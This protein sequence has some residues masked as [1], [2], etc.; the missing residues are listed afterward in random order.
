MFLVF[1]ILSLTS[2][3]E[4][5]ETVTKQGFAT[6][7]VL[8]TA[9]TTDIKDTTNAID[10]TDTTNIDSTNI[11][12]SDTVPSSDLNDTDTLSDLNDTDTLSDLD[13]NFTVDEIAF[14]QVCKFKIE[15]KVIIFFFFG[16]VS[17]PYKKGESMRMK[18][19]LTKEDNSTEEEAICTIKEDVNATDGEMK[20]ADL[21]C[22]IDVEKPEEYQGVEVV[23]SESVTGVP[24]E[25]NLLNPAKVDELIEMGE[26]KD[27]SLPENKEEK[28]PIFNATSLDTKDSDKTGAF[29]INGHFPPKF[30]LQR[31]FDFILRLLTGQRVVCTIPRVHPDKNEIR[32]ECVIQQP[33]KGRLMISPC[34][35][36]SGYNEIIRL[37]KIEAKDPVN[38]PNGRDF[39]LNRRFDLD[40]AFGQLNGFLRMTKL[41]F[42]NFVGFVF[43]P[44]KKGHTITMMVNLLK[45]GLPVQQ[46][47]NCTVIKDITP[48]PKGRGQVKFDCKV[49]KVE[50]PEEFEGLE[51]AESEDISGI[52]SDP[53]LLNPAK[54]DELIEEDKVENYTSKDVEVPVFNPTSIDTKDAEEK[55]VFYI[56]GK[57]P[58]GFESKKKFEFEV[59]L[60]S[61]EKAL[62]TLPKVN[63][64][65]KEIKIECVLEKPL[66]DVKIYIQ[67][68]SAREGPK[69]ILIF[70]KTESNEKV[71]ATNGR[72]KKIERLFNIDLLFGQLRKFHFKPKEKEITFVLIG[73]VTKPIKKGDT[74]KLDA[75]LKTKAPEDEEDDDED[76]D[77]EDE[78]EE[79]TCQA[80]KD[81]KP[82][83]KLK[84]AEFECTVKVEEEF[85]GIEIVAS[86]E[87]TGIP[88]DKNLRNPGKVELLIKENKVKDFEGTEEIDIPSFNAT[89]IDTKD[90]FKT[91][92]FFIKGLLPPKFVLKK[93]FE[94][95]V[96]LMTG[97]KAICTFPKVTDA[98]NEI[99]I[100]CVLQETLIDTQIIIQQFIVMDGFNEVMRFNK[101]NTTN[102]V[103]IA[104]GKERK[105]A[106]LFGVWL[107]F[108]QLCHF[109]PKQKEKLISFLFYGF[110]SQPIKK[111]HN[112]T[113]TVNLIKD[114][115]SVE[116]E[117]TCV[118][119]KEA[120]PSKEKMPKAEF[121]CVVKSVEKPEEYTGL[122]L[123]ESEEIAGIPTDPDL[124]NPAT[125]DELIELGEVKNFT[126]EEPEEVPT[127]EEPFIDTNDSAKTGVI[128]IE[129]ELSDEYKPKKE[130]EFEI[131]LMT[132]EKLKCKLPRK[133]I[134]GHIRIEC[135]LQEELNNVKI[136]IQQLV[137]L[138]G[139]NE[140]LRIK[141]VSKEGK[142]KVGNGKQIK[143]KKRFNNIFSFG[144][145]NGFAPKKDKKLIEFIFV[146][147]AN[148]PVKKDHNIT[149]TV[150]LLKDGEPVEE[151]AN[152]TAKADVT[153]VASGEQ[154]LVDFDCKVENVNKP[155]EYTGLE[156][157]QSEDVNSI[158]D[159]PDLLNPAKVDELIAE[160]E[161]R[162]Y[163]SEDEKEKIESIPE[164]NATSIDTSHSKNTGKFKIKGKF[165]T[166]LEL[167]EDFKFEITLASGQKAE[168]KLPKSNTKD[169]VVIECELQE[170]LNKTQLMIPQGPL[171]DGYKEVIKINKVATNKEVTIPSGK[172]VKFDK[173]FNSK[174]SFRQTHKFKFDKS[175]KMVTFVIAA[176][177]SGPVEK[178]DEITVDVSLI[179]PLETNKT[180]ATCKPNKEIDGAKP[181]EPVTFECEVK[182]IETDSDTEILSLD[183]EESSNMTDIPEDP[184]LKNPSKTDTLIEANE[185]EEA[186]DTDELPNFNATEID[187]TSA[188]A[189]G[190]FEIE[191][192]PL[193]DITKEFVFNITLVTGEKAL[194]K[195]PKSPKG[196]KAFIVCELDGT[197]EKTKIMIPETTVK[198]GY[199]ELFN[200]N[201]IQSKRKV[202]CANGKLKKMEKKKD[203]KI[204][205]R[206]ISHFKPNG[207]DKVKFIFSAFVLENM[208]KGKTIDMNVNL[209]KGD[210]TFLNANATCTLKNDVSGSNGEDFECEVEKVENA[211]KV[212]G[213]ELVESE[214]ISGV[215]SDPNMTNTSVVDE[216]IDSGEVK[217]LTED[218]NKKDAPPVF[219]PKSINGLGCR[220]SG[221]FSIK[222]KFNKKID[223][224]FR[225]NLPLSYPSIDARCTV[226]ESSSGEEVD[227]TCQTR[228]TFTKSKIIIEPTTVS[229]NNTE[230][231]TMKSAS[232]DDEISCEDYLAVSLRNKR[233]KFK[234]PFSFR[235]AQNFDNK[236]GLIKF[237]LFALLKKDAPKKVQS[238]TIE[239]IEIKVVLLK[240]GRRRLNSGD[241]STPLNIN[242]DTKST[243]G[244]T[245]ELNCEGKGEG[246]GVVVKGSDDLSGVP[247]DE[248]SANPAKVDDKIKKNQLV[249]C[250]G[251]KCASL[252][253]FTNAKIDNDKCTK[254]TI[255]I[256]GEIEDKE[257][258]L[259]DGAIFDLSYFP[260]SYGDCQIDKSK[261]LIECYNKEEIENSIVLVEETVVKAANGT[262]LFLLEGGVKSDKDDL[263]FS[264]S[265]KVHKEEEPNATVTDPTSPPVSSVKNNYFKKES[266]D[267][268]LSGGA[269]AGIV[270]ACVVAVA[271]AIA[272]IYF[273]KTGGSKSVEQV[274]TIPMENS[275]DIGASIGHF[276]ATV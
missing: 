34:A 69:E 215:P 232:L 252:P 56:N 47:A 27:Y 184:K 218:K 196:K 134:K 268:G 51:L 54:V 204:S 104:N 208:K 207:N 68:F 256:K 99:K 15:I 102:K 60:L 90:S 139:F 40:L 205:F 111:D 192:E 74:I 86:E 189:D 245:A 162:N 276:K 231:V 182:N 258:K 262:D 14:R 3:I 222:G 143:L 103:N 260:D 203:N 157:T 147:F 254:D 28:I 37:N 84:K 66:T 62:C 130:V 70:N 126:S 236:N 217:D 219:E 199:K 43:K 25:P 98:D 128:V 80:K 138:D 265:D 229:K 96:L 238:K 124:L 81:V 179:S 106:R 272:V 73:F 221:Q 270:I 88:A 48:G 20:Q 49:D 132:G 17:K 33:F 89:E 227:V 269:I 105:I 177:A 181:K 13:G 58:E 1:L 136:M 107:S 230:V 275:N 187:A 259:P 30:E 146:A 172:Q 123:V 92:I 32:I 41:I 213:V 38:M 228:S 78:E 183:I 55:G 211:D 165:M 10:T 65:A 274:E 5:D 87:I 50:E 91:G 166:E 176:F 61:G 191:G 57:V 75:K 109:L 29:Y 101:A 201:K 127:L 154:K 44:I 225:F 235:Q 159:E 97:E 224:H 214:E 226:P 220:S 242:C 223:K 8:G 125:V 72:E 145:L 233:K 71:N 76:E 264:I 153:D 271:A 266:S 117:A 251:D 131:V 273:V 83:G 188:I 249:D 2:L 142:V 100:E 170:E 36:F 240:D 243:Q 12:L 149:M 216:L 169:E 185:V 46:E 7:T 4:C 167:D 129:G 113:M 212:K 163:T 200:L 26:I 85:K 24:S 144:Q 210:N 21:E 195:L 148:K 79:V 267:R 120:T 135:E 197:L 193:E 11:D 141:S 77:E 248:N 95:E 108:G 174:L 209:D 121:E 114:G 110:V 140:V 31:S 246:N 155:D 250:T 171:F 115:E 16:V 6:D 253:K 118:A 186:K 257:G 23:P 45:N 237:V 122:E 112:I 263:S 168:C 194:C 234:A 160:G 116:E 175:K 247:S 239:T 244:D 202:T 22:K 94:F 261:K 19:L 133:N 173:K 9:D 137:A 255:Y 59:T 53:D 63:K 18:T 52:P 156:M 42:F 93:R 150:N 152:C 190:T 158:P 64:K 178:N 164:L 39:K 35:A 151:K 119:S 82:D 198:S 180:E 161:I 241:N 206:Q 67:S